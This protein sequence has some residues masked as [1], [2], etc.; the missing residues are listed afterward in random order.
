MFSYW[1]Q[2]SFLEYDHIIIGSGL[3]G[4]NTA[5]ELVDLFPNHKILV[6]ERGIL[7]TGASTKNAGFACM[8]SVTELLDDLMHSTE[9]EVIGLYEKRKKGLELLMQR[10]DKD[11]IDYKKNGSYELI[12]REEIS[13]LE[14]IGYLNKLLFDIDRQS[15]FALANDK[16]KSFGFSAAYTT[17]LIENLHEGELHTGKMMKALLQLAFS[18]KIEIKTGAEVTEFHQGKN[19]VTVEVTNNFHKP[20]HFRCKTLS[21]CTNAFTK[22]LLPDVNLQPGRGQVLVTKTIHNLPFKGIFHFDKGYYYFREIEGRVLF[23]GG[24]NVDFETEETTHFALNEKI[25]NDL[26]EK[27]KTVILPA[28]PFE[29]DTR[30][31][32]IMA[33]GNKKE[34]IVKTFS[35]NVF[36]AFRMG[37][38]GVALASTI[39][40]ELAALIK[41]NLH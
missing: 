16:I 29:T 27:L 13:C 28:T 23:G 34:P 24:R 38:M 18:K 1:E 5:I 31:C 7:P 37:G 17:A 8:G 36:G 11:I 40:Q 12:S 20:V 35:E 19:H 30:W 9:D 26:E 4:L 39:A 2:Q 33:F 14:K 22:Q 32:G 6:L 3:V 15:S 21:I 41:N 10:L 25:Q